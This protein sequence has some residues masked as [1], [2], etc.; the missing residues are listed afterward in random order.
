MTIYWHYF[1]K[2]L[3]FDEVMQR[4]QH[5]NETAQHKKHPSA[6]LNIDQI[7]KANFFIL[8]IIFIVMWW[9]LF[10]RKHCYVACI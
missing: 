8:I 2:K 5:V 9:R 3:N 7:I 4:A 6:G 1:H 10:E